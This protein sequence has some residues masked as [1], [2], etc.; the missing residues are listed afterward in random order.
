MPYILKSNMIEKLQTLGLF[1]TAWI[2]WHESCC[3]L[4]PS[5]PLVKKMK[6]D[7]EENRKAK[8]IKHYYYAS[9]Y[10]AFLHGPVV[11]VLALYSWIKYGFEFGE[12]STETY[13]DLPVYISCGYFMVDGCMGFFKKYET[14]DI[15]FHHILMSVSLLYVLLSDQDKGF[16]AA[17]LFVGECS[18]PIL[19][20]MEIVVYHESGERVEELVQIFY[21]ILFLVL[22]TPY[23]LITGMGL[24]RGNSSLFVKCPTCLMAWLSLDWSWAYLNKICKLLSKRY[25]ENGFL[26]SGYEGMVK[27]RNYKILYTGCVVLTIS[28]NL[29]A[30]F[31]VF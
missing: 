27:A 28:Y 9:C 10:I 15:T 16:L 14:F 6:T 21:S 7:T 29:L 17:T 11:S 20:I 23:T 18:N 12:I 19:S 31:G 22:R 2:I 1:I 8:Q 30:R 25:P 4:I 13:Y 26:R 3:R 24:L 5:P